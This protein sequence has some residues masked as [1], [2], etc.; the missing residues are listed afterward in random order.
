VPAL[1]GEQDDTDGFVPH[2]PLVAEAW[3]RNP[4]WRVPRSGLVLHTL[5]PAVIEQKVTGAEAFGAQ[6]RLARRYGTPAP[7]PG[8]E[9]ALMVPPDAATWARIPSW[10]WLKAGVDQAR[11]ASIMRALVSPGR[12]EECAGLPLADAHRRLR[13]IPGVG[14][15]TAA[16]V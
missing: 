15:W 8:A 16:E 7:G 10:E 6:R 13:S 5:I 11:S 4:G 3:R 1:L 2:H 12:L 14:V 9:L